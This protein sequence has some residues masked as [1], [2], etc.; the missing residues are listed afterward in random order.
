MGRSAVDPLESIGI[1]KRGWWGVGHE[2]WLFARSRN[3]SQGNK[4]DPLR[5]DVG[6]RSVAKGFFEAGPAED[7][8][9]VEMEQALKFGGP[10][11]FTSGETIWR[12]RRVQRVHPWT[13]RNRL[14]RRVHPGLYI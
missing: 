3:N 1:G 2:L 10:K 9:E 11:A 7:Q 14:G 6:K 8:A 13:R 12:A 5:E 4:K